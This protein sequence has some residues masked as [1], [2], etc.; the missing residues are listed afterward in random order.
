MPV[1][2]L[3]RAKDLDRFWVQELPEH[4]GNRIQIREVHRG[5][6]TSLVENYP[7]E[8]QVVIKGDFEFDIP[9]R[10]DDHLT[11]AGQYEYR[12][13]SGIFLVDT[14]TDLID[15]EEVISELNLRIS[16]NAQIKDALPVMREGLWRFFEQARSV[17]MLLLKGQE[18]RYDATLLLDILQ[19][20]EPLEYLDNIELENQRE[21]LA[22]I[23]RKYN[24][25]NDVSSIGDLDIDLYGTIIEEAAA[26][27]WKFG[28]TAQVTYKRGAFNIDA[29]GP[30]SR[31]FVIQ[32]I[33]KHVIN[34]NNM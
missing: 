19:N 29:E 33:E 24:H 23:I 10:R 14:P 1:S 18:G 22:N 26:T 2:R 28:E 32:L 13:G 9:A 17:E 6:A 21:T 31:E 20:E 25:R 34:N 4:Q 15:P 30:E 3:G 7:Y 5:N 16:E 11:R 12:A 8:G 27:Y